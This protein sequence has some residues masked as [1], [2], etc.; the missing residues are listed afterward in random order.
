VN[1]RERKGDRHTTRLEDGSGEMMRGCRVE[2]TRTMAGASRGRF[3]PRRNTPL[4]PG[5]L[6]PPRQ[7]GVEL[8]DGCPRGLQ[9]AEHIL[10]FVRSQGGA[11]LRECG[12]E[13]F[14]E[15]AVGAASCGS[16]PAWPATSAGLRSGST[17]VTSWQQE[18]A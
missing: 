18:R 3:R 9:F 14:W 15:V 12:C 13:S 2:D 6:P 17:D 1:A 16:R 10:R 8:F 5:V 4:G 7:Y 11:G